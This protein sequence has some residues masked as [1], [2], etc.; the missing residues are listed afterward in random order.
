HPEA[1]RDGAEVAEGTPLPARDD[2]RQ[3]FS[4]PAAAKYSSALRVFVCCSPERS[5]PCLERSTRVS[6]A[7]LKA[8]DGSQRVESSSTREPSGYSHISAT[9][10]RSNRSGVNASLR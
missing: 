3:A 2:L 1:G 8:S 9:S 10:R 5:T 7:T 6:A 4:L